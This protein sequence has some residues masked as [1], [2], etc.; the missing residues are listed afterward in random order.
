[1]IRLTDLMCFIWLLFCILAGLGKGA[2]HL[3][4]HPLVGAVLGFL[5]FCAT[6]VAYVGLS[7]LIER[8]RRRRRTP[9]AGPRRASEHIELRSW[10]EIYRD[11]PSDAYKMLAYAV[12]EYGAVWP[13][14]EVM[15]LPGDRMAAE[16]WPRVQAALRQ[17]PVKRAKI[18][19]WDL[20][21][22]RGKKLVAVEQSK[23]G[24]L[25]LTIWHVDRPDR[26]PCYLGDRIPAPAT[27]SA[28]QFHELLTEAFR[29]CRDF[30]WAPPELSSVA[31]FV[32]MFLDEGSHS[33]HLCDWVD[34]PGAPPT[35]HT[36]RAVTAWGEP[37]CMAW[38]DFMERGLARIM[39]SLDEYPSRDWRRNPNPR[40]SGRVVEN[41]GLSRARRVC[42]IRREPGT[43][44]AIQLLPDDW[45]KELGGHVQASGRCRSVRRDCAPAE[46]AEEVRKAFEACQ[47]T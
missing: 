11:E 9:R 40:P 24:S 36:L 21:D 35:Q 29:Q 32:D 39:R 44:D 30:R 23:D 16:A 18:P 17:N 4:V 3:G 22:S 12:E 37:E 15:M 47:Y 46:F 31:G 13:C 33:V 14:G 10:V 20:F 7:D 34:V 25:S 41:T 8:R 1:M 45:D 26:D 19:S 5:F 43:W 6:V 2:K 38:E 42:A 27:I 28:G